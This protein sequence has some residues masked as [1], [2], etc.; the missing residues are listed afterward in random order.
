M[1]PGVETALTLLGALQEADRR[2]ILEHLPPAA[3]ARLIGSAGSPLDACDA[4]D[5]IDVLSDEPAWL[6]HA[7]L[8]A[9]DW[10]WKAE[11]MGRLPATMQMQINALARA[12]VSLARPAVEFL[13]RS[14]SE[15]L[16]RRRSTP[17][18]DSLVMDFTR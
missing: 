18:F 9:G 17:K 1:S 7:V 8:S 11:L 10:R 6:I 14:L 3:Q 12:G 2:W 16:E 4:N 5:M 13:L 15:R